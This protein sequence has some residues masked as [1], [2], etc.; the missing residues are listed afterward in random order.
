[1]HSGKSNWDTGCVVN[2][3]SK[4]SSTCIK[5]WSEVE[6]FYHWGEKKNFHLR[7]VTSLIL[8]M[9]PAAVCEILTSFFIIK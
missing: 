3:V 7:I 1:M 2:L 6:I 8:E 4:V 9:V 5:V